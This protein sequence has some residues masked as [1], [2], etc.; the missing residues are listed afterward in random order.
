MKR[1]TQIVPT[2]CAMLRVGLNEA[3]AA[4]Y[5]ISLAN[6]DMTL[7]QMAAQLEAMKIM[8]PIGRMKW[9]ASMVAPVLRSPLRSPPPRSA[10][11]TEY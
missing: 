2:V 7:R 11:S 8:S 6:P 3:R 9:S 10:N 4:A 1:E 5:G